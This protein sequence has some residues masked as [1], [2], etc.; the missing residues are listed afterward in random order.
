MA[1]L[2]CIC[3]TGW[4]L[5]RGGP[6]CAPHLEFS[7]ALRLRMPL[8]LLAADKTVAICEG[9]WLAAAQTQMRNQKGMF[10]ELSPGP[11]AP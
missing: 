2:A 4:W 10:R 3:L 9:H 11:L 5:R 8:A 7:R 1:A 6:T